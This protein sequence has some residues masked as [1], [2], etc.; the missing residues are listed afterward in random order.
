MEGRASARVPTSKLGLLKVCPLL[1]EVSSF[2]GFCPAGRN[3]T[4]LAI[5]K[6]E[7][8]GEGT[9]L[10]TPSSTVCLELST[11]VLWCPLMSCCPVMCCAMYSVLCCV[12]PVLCSDVH[13]LC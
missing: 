5:S 13:D 2:I 11:D 7:V 3:K 8:E 1:S 10:M 6:R 9:G 12:C 4:E